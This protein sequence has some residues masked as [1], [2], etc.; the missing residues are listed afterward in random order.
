MHVSV[1]VHTR[2]GE[3][4]EVRGQLKH[5]PLNNKQT[6]NKLS[7]AWNLSQLCRLAGQQN[8]SPLL[9]PAPRLQLCAT[10]PISGFVVWCVRVCVCLFMYESWDQP[11]ALLLA[12]QT[13]YKLSY[14]P[15]PALQALNHM[16]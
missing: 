1:V 5:A 9:G 4:V 10:S 7:L 11:Q 8:L 13:F 12:R 3:H 6:N 15:Y 14:L 16:R 2:V